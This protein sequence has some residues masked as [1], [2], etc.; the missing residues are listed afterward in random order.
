MT[1]APPNTFDDELGCGPPSSVLDLSCGW[2]VVNSCSQVPKSGGKACNQMSSAASVLLHKCLLDG[3][4][5]SESPSPHAFLFDD[6]CNFPKQSIRH[7]HPLHRGV[8][9]AKVWS[10]LFSS[11]LTLDTT[12]SDTGHDWPSATLRVPSR[13]DWKC[14]SLLSPKFKIQWPAFHFALV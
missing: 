11:F 10:S 13:R 14:A 8:K 4:E 1:S 5:A 7:A 6:Y 2:M 9:V 12:I 3:W